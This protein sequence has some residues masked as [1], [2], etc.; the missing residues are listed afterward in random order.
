MIRIDITLD[1]NDR[2]VERYVTRFEFGIF[3]Y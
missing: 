2:S 3:W 1:T